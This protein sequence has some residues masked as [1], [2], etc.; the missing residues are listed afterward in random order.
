MDVPVELFEARMQEHRM[1]LAKR[2]MQLVRYRLCLEQ[3]GI[4]PPDSD[5]EELLEMWRNAER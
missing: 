1:E 5:G 3:H 2:E 4:D